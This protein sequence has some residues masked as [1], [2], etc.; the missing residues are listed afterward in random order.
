MYFWKAAR[1]TN[2]PP[3]PHQR[4]FEMTVFVYPNL[5]APGVVDHRKEW[6]SGWW[7]AV[8]FNSSS[9]NRFQESVEN[10][11]QIWLLYYVLYYCDNDIQKQLEEPLTDK[12]E[13]I[14]S[15]QN[16]PQ[17]Q[18]L[19]YSLLSPFL[20]H[21]PT[22]IHQSIPLSSPPTNHLWNSAPYTWFFPTP[23]LGRIWGYGRTFWRLRAFNSV[24][25]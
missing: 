1:L 21:V 10:E 12:I 13:L 9:P 7:K 11:I 18:P 2:I 23:T 14:L 4:I 3:A 24:F 15:K 20:G 22:H 16:T 8:F 19:D 5:L 25:W 6:F 17:P